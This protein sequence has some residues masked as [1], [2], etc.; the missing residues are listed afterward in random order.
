MSPQTQV[1]VLYRDMRTYAQKELYYKKA[2]EAG[3]R[4]VRYEPEQKPE[5]TVQDGDR[6][7]VTVFDQN[8]KLPI[9]LNPDFLVLSSAIRPRRRAKRCPRS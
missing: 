6:T 2:R 7:S 9:R 3:V 1:V 5:V 8:L 4:F